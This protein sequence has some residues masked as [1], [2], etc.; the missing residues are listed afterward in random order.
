[1]TWK[2]LT[3]LISPFNIV[4]TFF[5]KINWCDSILEQGDNE[6]RPR[7]IK[8]Y[9]VWRIWWWLNVV[10]SSRAKIDKNWFVKWF[11][12]IWLFLV[13]YLWNSYFFH[14]WEFYTAL[15]CSLSAR[16]LCGRPRGE[17]NVWPTKQDYQAFAAERCGQNWNRVFT[18]FRSK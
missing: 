18:F 6:Y 8:I 10:K 12:S 1:M 15:C 5:D 17:S 16:Y 11:Y 4:L 3:G 14:I 13:S 2:R 9:W 7:I